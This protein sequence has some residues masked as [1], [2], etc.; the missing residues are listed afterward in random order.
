[1]IA[2]IVGLAGVGFVL[3]VRDAL[4]RNSGALVALWSAAAIVCFVVALVGGGSNLPQ[5]ECRE[6][7]RFASEC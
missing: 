1:M 5:F 2:V 4:D 6:Y 3:L 7:G